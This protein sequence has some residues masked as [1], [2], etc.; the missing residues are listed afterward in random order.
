MAR[1]SKKEKAIETAKPK[2]VRSKSK[3]PLREEVKKEIPKGID[4]NKEVT[5]GIIT[6]HNRDVKVPKDVLEINEEYLSDEVKRAE[7]LKMIENG[8]L[9]WIYYSMGSRFYKKILK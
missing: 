6:Y 5:S 1:I 9:K 2:R 4:K 3:K 8:E 7:F